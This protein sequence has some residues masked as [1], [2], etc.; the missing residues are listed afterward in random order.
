MLFLVHARFFLFTHLEYS[1]RVHWKPLDA[2][3]KTSEGI[4]SCV[5]FDL[6][7]TRLK[8]H[9]VRRLETNT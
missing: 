2:E 8:C 1:L 6:F 5:P 4:A 3:R 7:S 9:K